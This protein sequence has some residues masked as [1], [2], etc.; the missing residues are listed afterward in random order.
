ME[1]RTVQKSIFH[2]SISTLDGRYQ[3]TII[4]QPHE[5]NLRLIELKRCLPWER[6]YPFFE[7][8]TSEYISVAEFHIETI[9]FLRNE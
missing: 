7:Y 2:F 6:S 5:I 4:S 8:T 3:R 9:V 1:T